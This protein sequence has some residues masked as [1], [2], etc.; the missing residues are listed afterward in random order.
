[1]MSAIYGTEMLTD[2][3]SNTQA[4]STVAFFYHF[5]VHLE[6][7]QNKMLKGIHAVQAVL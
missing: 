1:M 4:N 2:E 3:K 7:F 5:Y 6:L